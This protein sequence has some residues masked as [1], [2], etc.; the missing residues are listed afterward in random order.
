M[1]RVTLYCT[2]M[3]TKSKMY[4]EYQRNRKSRVPSRARDCG[5]DYRAAAAVLNPRL[6]TKLP[7]H[8]SRSRPARSTTASRRGRRRTSRTEPGQFDNLDER[9]PA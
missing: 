1:A 3:G 5:F 6:L 7:R 4:R 9:R 2:R 8:P